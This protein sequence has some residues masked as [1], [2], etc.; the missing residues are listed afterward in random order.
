MLNRID[1]WNNFTEQQQE[2]CQQ[3]S[4]EQIL[5]NNGI[6]P[7]YRLIE[8][9]LKEHND[10]HIDKIVDELEQKGVDVSKVVRRDPK[11]KKIVSEVKNLQF[12]SK[13]NNYANRLKEAFKKDAEVAIQESISNHGNNYHLIFKDGTKKATYQLII[14]PDEG[15]DPLVKLSIVIREGNDHGF[16]LP[17]WGAR[18]IPVSSDS[19]MDYIKSQ[20]QNGVKQSETV[21]ELIKQGVKIEDVTLFV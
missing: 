14:T 8:E 3:N 9:I 1:F 4:D 6:S 19:L 13:E 11:T 10:C 17:G 18:A 20:L 2:E 15:K 16:D 12:Y 21:T 5:K 7:I